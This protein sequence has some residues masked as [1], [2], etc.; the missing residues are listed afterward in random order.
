MLF[1]IFIYSQTNII[2]NFITGLSIN[3]IYIKI[4]IIVDYLIKK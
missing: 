1:I 4:L 2:L 3:K